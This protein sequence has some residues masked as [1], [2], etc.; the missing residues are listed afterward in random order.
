[1]EPLGLSSRCRLDA[2]LSK[3]LHFGQWLNVNLS[4]VPRKLVPDVT[5]AKL[6]LATRRVLPNP[7]WQDLIPFGAV[8]YA[9]SPTRTGSSG[10]RGAQVNT[11]VGVGVSASLKTFPVIM[12][13]FLLPN[14]K[15]MLPPLVTSRLGSQITGQ[16]FTM[17]SWFSERNHLPYPTCPKGFAANVYHRGVRNEMRD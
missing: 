15:A 3:D 8:V 13:Y 5:I 1:M 16:N 7:H 10:A 17:K 12:A 2:W 11:G 14:S 4:L 6:A 9:L